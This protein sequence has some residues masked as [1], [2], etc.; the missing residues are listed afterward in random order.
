MGNAN[1]ALNTLKKSSFYF[2]HTFLQILIGK[3]VVGMIAWQYHMLK[4]QSFTLLQFKQHHICDLI[5]ATAFRAVHLP[6]SVVQ[7]GG[8]TRRP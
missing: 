1:F 7:L 5:A 6:W 8:C 4:A 2:E 3:G